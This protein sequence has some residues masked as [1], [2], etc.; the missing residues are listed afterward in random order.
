[1]KPVPPLPVLIQELVATWSR[2]QQSLRKVI[3]W[4][5]YVKRGSRRQDTL[6]HSYSFALFALC[7]FPRLR[8][9]VSFDEHLVLKAILLHDIG[10]GEVKGDTLYVDKNHEGDIAECA[11]FLN[12]FGDSFG[13]EGREAF[14]LQFAPKAARM[15]H[16]E[17]ELK[18]LFE[19][20]SIESLVFEAVER[21]DYLLYALEQWVERRQVKILVQVLRNQAQHFNRL[22]LELPGFRKELWTLELEEWSHDLLNSHQGKWIEQKGEK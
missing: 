3:R 18:I 8:M 21:F 6:Q 15:A 5:K 1:M 7:L 17:E 13:R 22:S 20:R 11:A 2:P 14:L 12:R 10:E 9:H 19:R 4:G 16:Y